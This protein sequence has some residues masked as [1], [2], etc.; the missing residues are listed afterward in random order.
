[1]PSLPIWEKIDPELWRRVK[2][3]LDHMQTFDGR[4]LTPKM[5]IEFLLDKWL[6]SQPK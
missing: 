1:M 6:A 5:L 4:P 2:A 3:K